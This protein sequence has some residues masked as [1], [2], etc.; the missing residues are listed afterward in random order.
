MHSSWPSWRSD[1]KFVPDLPLD[2][3]ELNSWDDEVVY[4][5]CSHSTF[6][7]SCGRR[8][9]HSDSI[10][11]AVDGAC[12]NNGM[13]NVPQYASIGVYA[14]EYST[15]NV[16]ERLT[17]RQVSANLALTNQMAELYAGIRGLEVAQQIHADETTELT[18]LKQVI[19]KSDSMYL[20]RG[21][22]EWIFKWL[23]NGWVNA[24]GARV[25]NWKLFARLDE[26]VKQ[27][28][29]RG[30]EVLF[31][32]VPR[33]YNA[34]ADALANQALDDTLGYYSYY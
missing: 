12:R 30:V 9:A 31:W 13:I 25:V 29:G 33:E 28:N 6:C 27:L 32:L 15:Y 34:E 7:P 8:A 20:V 18:P 21:M 3:I 19:I 22:T 23:A 24:K 17:P 1:R 4:T 10:I 14:N 2:E 5:V 16:A 26:L 11:I